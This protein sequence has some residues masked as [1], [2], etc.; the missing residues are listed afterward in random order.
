[1]FNVEPQERWTIEDAAEFERHAANHLRTSLQATI[2]AGMALL[3]NILCIIPFLSGYPMHD[4]WDHGAKY[5]L[6][7]AYLLLLWFVIKAGSVWA[8]WQSARET[9]RDF[10]DPA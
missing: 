6:I 2:W 1:M 3:A 8:S 5:L 10:G 9:R 4:Q 7:S